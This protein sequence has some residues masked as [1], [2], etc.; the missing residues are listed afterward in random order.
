[1]ITCKA[2]WYI[3]NKLRPYMIRKCSNCNLWHI[4]GIYPV[5]GM[6]KTIILE[7]FKSFWDDGILIINDVELEEI[8][9]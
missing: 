7:S 2:D 8:T 6:Y 3:M 1:M 4:I 9:S 5:N